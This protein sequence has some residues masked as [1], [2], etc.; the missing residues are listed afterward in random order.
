MGPGA[1]DVSGGV[2]FVLL[3]VL[4][5]LVL[6]PAYWKLFVTAKIVRQWPFWLRHL[7]GFI[8]GSLVSSVACLGALFL[9][10]Y[11]SD[12]FGLY[13][14]IVVLLA[15]FICMFLAARRVI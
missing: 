6:I 1:P 7:A 10:V 13:V 2:L 11:G 5:F 3:V 15:I 4:L 9:I 14:P 8:F 12:Y